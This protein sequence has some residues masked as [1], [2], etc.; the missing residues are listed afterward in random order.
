MIMFEILFTLRGSLICFLPRTMQTSTITTET[1][2]GMKLQKSS[3]MAMVKAKR[4]IGF[5][6]HRTSGIRYW[7]LGIGIELYFPIPNTQYPIPYNVSLHNERTVCRDSGN[8]RG[9]KYRAHDCYRF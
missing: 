7:V 9:R 1:T 8:E 6:L 4:L 2:A 3:S 5:H